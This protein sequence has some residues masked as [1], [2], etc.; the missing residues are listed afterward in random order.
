MGG[1][2]SAVGAARVTGT[3]QVDRPARELSSGRQ[4]RAEP[5]SGVAE[6]R[7]R[8]DVAGQLGRQRGGALREAAERDAG[9]RASSS[10]V[11]DVG[12]VIVG[13]VPAANRSS[14]GETS[15]LPYLVG[16]VSSNER[17]CT[18]HVHVAYTRDRVESN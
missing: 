6:D 18:P 15:E 5:G 14:G 8:C 13:A 7:D 12:G 17:G 16:G 10:H 2:I 11:G 4:R 1:P 3:A 9:A